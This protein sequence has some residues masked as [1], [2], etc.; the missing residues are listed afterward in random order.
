VAVEVDS[1]VM[2]KNTVVS[3][4]FGLRFLEQGNLAEFYFEVLGLKTR[5]HITRFGFF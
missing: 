3:G 4:D 5:R 1:K 2:L